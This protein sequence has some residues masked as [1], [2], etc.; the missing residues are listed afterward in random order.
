MRQLLS[1]YTY[2]CRVSAQMRLHVCTDTMTHTSAHVVG[3]CLQQARLVLIANTTS[4]HCLT[5]CHSQEVVPLRGG[6]TERVFAASVDCAVFTGVRGRTAEKRERESTNTCK[7]MHMCALTH[8][9]THTQ[10]TSPTYVLLPTRTSWA[11]R[12]PQFV[13]GSK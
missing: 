7:Y 2:T 5:L 9:H 4:T 3:H 13:K 10:T 8:V 11:E 1:T 12:W 6:H